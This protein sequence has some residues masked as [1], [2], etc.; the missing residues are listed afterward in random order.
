MV[1]RFI[2]ACAGN[3]CRGCAAAPPRAVHPRLRG[4][5]SRY[6]C[7]RLSVSG[8][9]PPARGTLARHRPGRPEQRF[10]P[11]CAGNTCHERRAGDATT[12][13]PRLRGEHAYS[14]TE[15]K[16]VNGSSPPARG[17]LSSINSSVVASRFI[18]ACAGNTASML[19]AGRRT[20]VHPRLRGEHPVT[21]KRVSTSNGSS[22]PARGTPNNLRVFNYDGRFIPACAG[23]TRSRNARFPG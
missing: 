22:P 21:H 10:I 6:S 11:A 16:P 23:N 20:T 15:M 4:E 1:A 9:S 14:L 12:V 7:A 17:T 2:P 18:P 13:H 8:S 19:P 5:H 3:T